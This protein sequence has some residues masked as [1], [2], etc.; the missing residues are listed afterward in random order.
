MTVTSADGLTINYR[1]I[2]SGPGLIVI[3]GALAVADDRA[4]LAGALSPDF[5]VH[6]IERRGRGGS[7]PQ[8]DNYCMA[9]E[10]EDLAAVQR[11]TGAS[12]VFGHSYGG[13]IALEA[14][15]TNKALTKVAV[16]EPGVSI[17]ESIPRHWVP[18][19]EASL[20]AGKP[21]DA[22]IAFAL[23]LGPERAEKTPYWI[24]RL[25]LAFLLRGE[26]RERT[27]AL[28]PAILREH[29]EIFRLDDSFENYREI[30]APVLWIYGGRSP[31]SITEIPE[32]LRDVIPRLTVTS[33]PGLNHFGP[34]KKKSATEIA[35]AI[36]EFLLTDG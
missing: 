9:R 12:W 26:E 28:L 30:S 25:V 35:A 15:R 1:S 27:L 31:A 7:G 8:G 33:F 34:E 10:C 18:Q 36:R 32:R 21:M 17:N 13:L 6:T 5:T 3:P 20:A 4:S 11:E 14:A 19:Y 16:Y 22:F 2:G 24:M 29:L 23:A